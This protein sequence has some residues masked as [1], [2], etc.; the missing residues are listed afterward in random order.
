MAKI[1][2][3]YSVT[4]TMKGRNIC[5]S[6]HGICHTF[7]E[8]KEKF[9]KYVNGQY[10]ISGCTRIVLYPHRGAPDYLDFS[11]E[12]LSRAAAKKVA[13][14]IKDYEVKTEPPYPVPYVK[15][16]IR[17]VTSDGEFEPIEAWEL[18]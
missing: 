8:A 9:R 12:R 18:S 13:G 16:A 15:A 2:E 10:M 5:H 11:E 4:Y 1:Y 7:K 3:Y 14:E 6:G 17:G